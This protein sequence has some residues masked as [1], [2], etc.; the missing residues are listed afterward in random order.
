LTDQAFIRRGLAPFFYLPISMTG[1]IAVG[2][3]VITLGRV[4]SD[5]GVPVA[6]I[7]GMIS[8]TLLPSTL[9][10]LIGPFI[11]MV[12]TP[13]RWIVICIVAI[14]AS[15]ALMAFTPL[16]IKA[17][18]M[19]DLL[20][21]LLGCASNAKG[22]AVAAAMA[23]TTPNAQRG[24]VAG[25]VNAGT[26]GGM[27]LGGG[28]GLWLAVHAGGV[29]VAGMV[30]ALAGTLLMAPAFWLRT[31][32]ID[33]GSG[34]VARVTE[35]LVVLWSLL[36]TRKGVL[37]AIVCLIP[38]SV[39]AAIGLLPAVARDW[40]A[41]ANMVALFTGLLAGLATIPG[42][43]LGG[44][45]CDLFPRRA[46]YVWASVAFAASEAAMALA[47]HTP[48]WFAAMVLLN[49]FTLG[50]G[51]AGVGA[52]MY[53]CLGER[54]AATVNTVLGSLSNIPLVAM[55]LVVGRVQTD[56]GSNAML[57][58]EALVAV[59]AI[60]GYSALAWLWKP[61]DLAVPGELAL[62]EG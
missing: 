3:V 39:G 19:V 47:P 36:R 25:W 45:L 32:P 55:T 57:M 7:A 48:F 49:A 20:A 31:P 10:F 16:S 51:Y 9:R 22:C 24:A 44:Y 30:L 4:L 21:F 53:D 2:F 54:G 35:I 14:F 6:Q 11:D 27:A 50:L 28:A 38:C 8:L 1:G 26:L 61:A 17:M 42:C 33:H 15:M 43:V 59:V 56:H 5:K 40:G 13:L 12:L 60:A 23:L 18:P 29:P 62:A 34:A 52:V 41:S 37:V 58:V 46:F